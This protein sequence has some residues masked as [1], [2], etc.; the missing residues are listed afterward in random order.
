MDELTKR[1]GEHLTSLA[2][3]RRLTTYGEVAAH[4]DM[5][6][7]DGLW[8]LHPLCEIFGALDLDDDAF[9]RPFRTSIVVRSAKHAADRIPGDGFFKMVADLRQIPKPKTSEEKLVLWAE[10]VRRLF[11][12][13]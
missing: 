2:R 11:E 3:E 5:K 8:Q 13:Q 1:I 9:S 6:P 10:E 4:F 12:F 7:V